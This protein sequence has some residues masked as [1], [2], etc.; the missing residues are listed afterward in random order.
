MDDDV[1]YMQLAL[2]QAEQPCKRARFPWRGAVH[3]EQVVAAAHN[4][5]GQSV[6]HAEKQV[7]KKFWPAARNIFTTTRSL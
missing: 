3:G 2:R 4:R 6:G 1:R 7:V 5:T